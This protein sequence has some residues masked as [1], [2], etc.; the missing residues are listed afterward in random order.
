MTFDS[1]QTDPP[2]FRHL[3][4]ALNAKGEPRRVGVEIEFA[5]LDEREVA[6]VLAEELGGAVEQTGSFDFSLCGSEIG[7]LSVELD[8]SLRKKSD[9]RLVHDGLELARGLIPVEV[10]TGPLTV[11]TLPRLNEALGALR[12]AGAKGSGQGVFYGFGVHL[13][14]E[15]AGADHPLTPATIRAYG[16]LEEHLRAEDRIDGTRRLLPFVDRWPTALITALADAESA[17]LRDLMVLYA[18]HTTNRNHGLDLLPL[19][20]HLDDRRFARLFGEGDGGITNARPT[21]HFRLPDSRI[22]EADWS[23]AQAWDDWRLVETV[24]GDEAA[25]KTLSEARLRYADRLLSGRGDWRRE[26]G[27][28]LA[29]AGLAA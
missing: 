23:L 3:P 13:N 25:M 28:I 14:P 5:G 19:F 8:A 21:F 7:D 12:R 16:L 20:R 26:S 15:I 17:S 1:P 18:R 27:A 10:I 9:M 24:A 6:R 22:D 29:D 11:E 2:A 4:V